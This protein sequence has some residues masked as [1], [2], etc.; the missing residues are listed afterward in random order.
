MPNNRCAKL[1]CAPTITEN[2]ANAILKNVELLVMVRIR[3]K[4]AVQWCHAAAKRMQYLE[5]IIHLCR[6]LDYLYRWY[7]GQVWYVP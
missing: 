1:H 7:L 5:R 2:A 3:L 4:L 6:Y